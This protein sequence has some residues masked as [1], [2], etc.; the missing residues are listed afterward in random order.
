MVLYFCTLVCSVKPTQLDQRSLLPLS[1]HCL[2]CSAPVRRRSL[3]TRTFA[4]TRLAP[5]PRRALVSAEVSAALPVR[6]ASVG[7]RSSSEY[8]EAFLMSELTCR[9]SCDVIKALKSPALCVCLSTS[10]TAKMV[11]L[12]P[13]GFLCFDMTPT[14]ETSIRAAFKP[15][16]WN[17]C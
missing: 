12:R 16:S 13:A 7:G 14:R 6:G 4:C 17:K 9:G 15:F 10:P 1:L 11:L 2:G 5:A 8:L 3:S